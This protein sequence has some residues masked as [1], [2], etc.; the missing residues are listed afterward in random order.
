MIAVPAAA[1]IP[2]ATVEVVSHQVAAS[3]QAV[4]RVWPHRIPPECR[5]TGTIASDPLEVSLRKLSGPKFMPARKVARATIEAAEFPHAVEGATAVDGSTA[6]KSTPTVESTPTI[7]AAGAAAHAT[8]KAARHPRHTA[9]VTHMRPT[10]A[11]HVATT[12]HATHVAAAATVGQRGGGHE[13][14]GRENSQNDDAAEG[15]VHRKGLRGETV[16][17]SGEGWRHF[18]E[19]SLSLSYVF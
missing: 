6:I 19:L 15:N 16:L 8:I 3:R 13:A 9:A 14:G 18:R 2:A 17:K 12:P 1:P 4:D 5:P 10:I 7:N 11:A